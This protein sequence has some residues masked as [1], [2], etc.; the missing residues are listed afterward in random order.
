MSLRD[1]QRVERMKEG[2]RVGHARGDGN[3]QRKRK[4]LM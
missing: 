1:E 2:K 4:T 3:E